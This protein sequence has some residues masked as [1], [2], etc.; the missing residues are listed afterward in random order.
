MSDTNL[1]NNLVDLAYEAI[2]SE[3][4]RHSAAFKDARSRPKLT[5][6]QKAEE[7]VDFQSLSQEGQRSVLTR[8]LAEGGDPDRW[9]ESRRKSYG[10][11]FQS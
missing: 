11:T 8:I 7:F 9:L 10:K 2:S 3:V 1:F 4:D 5:S 6:R